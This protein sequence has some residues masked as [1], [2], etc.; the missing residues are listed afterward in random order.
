MIDLLKVV[1]GLR[2]ELRG[3]RALLSQPVIVAAKHQSAW[4][5]LAFFLLARDPAYAMK[6]ELMAIPLYGW[7]ARK[8]AMIA[9]DRGAGGAAMRR[10]LRDAEAAIAQRRQVV[11]FP[12]GTRVAP[13]AQAP[14]QP[15]V[16]ALYSRLGVPV[17]P[18]ALNSGL[19]WGRR[20]FVKR[21][22]TIVVEILPPI[23]PGLPR[24]RF[25][26]EL[27]SRI[28]TATA[29]LEAGAT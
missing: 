11:I 17:V 26:A 6:K 15:G 21:P 1:V 3:D 9:I 8:Q 7:I 29:R 10:L 12:Q 16:A 24:A 20:S 18:I 14:Y 25:M 27:E 2:F 19:F 5:T 28:E 4:E 23:A 13:G 22:G